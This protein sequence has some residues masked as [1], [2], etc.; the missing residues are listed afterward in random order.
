MYGRFLFPT[1]KR[2]SLLRMCSEHIPKVKIAIEFSKIHLLLMWILLPKGCLIIVTQLKRLYLELALSRIL[3]LLLLLTATF[4]RRLRVFNRR[5][6]L[7]LVIKDQKSTYTTIPI[8]LKFWL[9]RGRLRARFHCSEAGK[10]W[11]LSICYRFVEFGLVLEFRI[12]T[13]SEDEGRLIICW[14]LINNA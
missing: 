4:P 10:I 6:I 1:F 2:W 8:N 14:I 5:I 13:W 9:I 12:C 3:L 11:L 7:I